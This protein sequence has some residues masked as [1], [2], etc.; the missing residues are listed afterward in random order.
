MIEEMPL[1]GGSRRELAAALARIAA[2][3]ARELSSVED[4]LRRIQND[5]ASATDAEL[6][7]LSARV[8]DALQDAVGTLDAWWIDED[9]ARCPPKRRRAPASRSRRTITSTDSEASAGSRRLQR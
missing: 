1:N 9:V 8:G 6:E 4:D 5:P 7:T 2:L 3:A